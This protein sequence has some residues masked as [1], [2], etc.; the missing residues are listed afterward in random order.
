MKRILILIAGF[1]LITVLSGFTF[2]TSKEHA[3][4]ICL[5]NC[6]NNNFPDSKCN[7][8][9][10]TCRHDLAA[11]NLSG[12]EYSEGLATCRVQCHNTCRMNATLTCR[13]NCASLE[14]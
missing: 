11:L 7:T 1:C 14:P 9:D 10:A 3:F 2:K 4:A 6:V 5:R 12:D 8:C 13:A